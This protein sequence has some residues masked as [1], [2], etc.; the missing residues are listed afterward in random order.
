VDTK[1]VPLLAALHTPI[2]QSGT[3][4]HEGLLSRT[5]VFLALH[6]PAQRPG[7]QRLSNNPES[8]WV[9]FF[10]VSK[11]AGLASGASYNTQ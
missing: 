9:P 8:V 6:H 7:A 3:S 1:H 10:S 4:R 5:D 11:N 2:G